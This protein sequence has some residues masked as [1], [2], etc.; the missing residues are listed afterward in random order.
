M[1]E[2]RLD[3]PEEGLFTRVT[4]QVTFDAQNTPVIYYTAPF[5]LALLVHSEDPLRVEFCFS[6]EET[7]LNT[8]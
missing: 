6:G 5:Y 4:N 7:R 1:K 8:L 2:E 3:L